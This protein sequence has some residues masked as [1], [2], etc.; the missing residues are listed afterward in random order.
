MIYIAPKSEW[1]ESL[2]EVH[3]LSVLHCV[4][5]HYTS[6][7]LV[8]IVYC[9]IQFHLGY[10]YRKLG[11]RNDHDVNVEQKRCLTFLAL[12]LQACVYC[13]CITYRYYC[14]LLHHEIVTNKT[15]Y[16]FISR[17][18]LHYSLTIYSAYYKGHGYWLLHVDS[19]TLLRKSFMNRSYLILFS[20]MSDTVC[21]MYTVSQKNCANLF[22]VT[23]L[24]NFDGL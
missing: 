24:P 11:P 2:G 15:Q 10:I 23:T 21:H 18:H 9:V 4:I 13:M 7:Q 5:L 3:R 22:F 1:T 16:G 14:R 12:G 6:K 19:L 8:R 20:C 17:R